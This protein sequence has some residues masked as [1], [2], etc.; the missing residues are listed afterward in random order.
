LDCWLIGWLIGRLVGDL[1]GWLVG[2]LFGW[3]IGRCTAIETFNYVQRLD[4]SV[5]GKTNFTL[6]RT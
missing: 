3:L 5:F 2:W 1:V 6:A 4:E